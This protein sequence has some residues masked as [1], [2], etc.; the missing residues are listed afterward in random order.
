MLYQLPN[1]KVINISIEQY[2]NM[3]DL[4]IQYLISV[5]GGDYATNPFTDSACI[6]NAKEKSY[7]FE[8][9][10]NDEELDDIADDSIPFDDI[11]DLTDNLDI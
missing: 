2:L 4:D 10:P 7:D 3:T 5:G 6:D 1:G 8:F 9:L 11:I